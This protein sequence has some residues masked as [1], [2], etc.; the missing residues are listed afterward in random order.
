MNDSESE[1]IPYRVSY[2]GRVRE[3]LSAFSDIAR[4]RG[5]QLAY[6]AA[7]LE[8]DRRLH[9]YPQF[10]EPLYDVTQSPGQVWLGIVPPLLMRYV[11]FDE[12][13]VVEVA[14]LPV[15]LPKSGP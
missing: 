12:L 4:E 6:Y 8:F 10:G 3:R 7:L 5:D 2:T 13:R 15:L 11:V 9:I 1:P 14:E